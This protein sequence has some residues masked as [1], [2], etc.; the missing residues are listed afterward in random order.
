[1]YS[2]KAF[3]KV[4][5]APKT[6]ETPKRGRP[7]GAK[8][9]GKGVAEAPA[10]SSGSIFE[11]TYG[12]VNGVTSVELL[13]GMKYRIFGSGNVGTV[14]VRLRL[15]FANGE[16]AIIGPAS[17][18]FL[19]DRDDSWRK[20]TGKTNNRSALHVS[21]LQ[22]WPADVAGQWALII[23]SFGERK[24]KAGETSPV[25]VADDDDDAD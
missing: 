9:K 4:S 21:E 5:E 10:K 17:M 12:R 14:N 25:V 11:A 8:N 16:S 1:V 22:E 24:I 3:R 15:N 20:E 13:D 7:V 18:T 2:L 19:E 6:A 23:E